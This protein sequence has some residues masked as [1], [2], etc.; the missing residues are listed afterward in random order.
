VTA[1]AWFVAGRE[2]SSRETAL[3]AI[4]DRDALLTEVT[5]ASS[6]TVTVRTET[7]PDCGARYRVEGVMGGLRLMAEGPPCGCG[8]AR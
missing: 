1:R 4:G 5:G 8:G 3:D 6:L 2:F 7:C